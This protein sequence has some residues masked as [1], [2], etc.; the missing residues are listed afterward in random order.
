MMTRTL[1]TSRHRTMSTHPAPSTPAANAQA[2]ISPR[3]LQLQSW[4]LVVLGALLA[5]GLSAILFTMLPT[6]SHPGVAIGGST[7]TGTSAQA[8][9]FIVLLAA[10]A[11]LGALFCAVGI[12]QLATGRGSRLRWVALFLIPVVLGLAWSSAS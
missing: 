11:L 1:L 9:K 10:V 4:L 8:G 5:V 2:P 12:R 6:L 3:R 7:F